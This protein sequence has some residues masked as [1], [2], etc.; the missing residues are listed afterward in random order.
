MSVAYG[1]EI[2]SKNDPWVALAEDA[3]QPFVDALVPGAFLVDSFPF[4]KHVPS[5]MPG[6]GF[7]RKAQEW[8]EAGFKLVNEPVAVAKEM[9]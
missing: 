7:K 3:V 9:M 4:L 8:K 2:K 6:A 5:W 1:I